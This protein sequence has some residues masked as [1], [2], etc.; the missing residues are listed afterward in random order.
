MHSNYRL[1][2]E[3]K[4]HNKTLGIHTCV[5]NRT[6][7][8]TCLPTQA[9]GLHWCYCL[10]E[11]HQGKGPQTPDRCPSESATH[12]HTHTQKKK[13]KKKKPASTQE[14]RYR[15]MVWRVC[16][17]FAD[18]PGKA[19]VTAS[20][21]DPRAGG[22]GRRMVARAYQCEL[23]ACPGPSALTPLGSARECRPLTDA[24][25]QVPGKTPMA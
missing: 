21:R 8:R 7:H 24:L 23:K 22:H 4:R 12:T 1:S 3:H 5:D 2:S 13:K 18:P 20:T 19:N 6:R 17:Q 16:Q 25:E 15:C 9:P 10:K 11:E 14:R